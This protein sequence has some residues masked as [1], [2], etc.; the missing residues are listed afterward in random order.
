MCAFTHTHLHSTKPY[1]Q[2]EQE[3]KQSAAVVGVESEQPCVR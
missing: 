3:A 2:C 1:L